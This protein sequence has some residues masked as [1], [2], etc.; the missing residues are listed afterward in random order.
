MADRDV[1]D[2]GSIVGANGFVAHDVPPMTVVGG[3]PAEFIKK[4]GVKKVG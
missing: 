4:I 3:H 2:S 1:S